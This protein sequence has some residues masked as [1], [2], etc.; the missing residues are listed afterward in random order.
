MRDVYVIGVGM[1]RFGKYLERTMKDMAAECVK[2]VLK[3]A[4]IGKDELQFAYVSNGYWGLFEGQ[5][6]IKGQVLLFPLGIQKIPITNVE[7]A[8][9]GASTAFHLAWMSI[10]SGLYDVGLALGVEKLTHPDKEL[11][12]KSFMSSMD[13]LD[14]ANQVQRMLSAVQGLP[15]KPP[16]EQEEAGRGRSIFM[17][18]YAV[19]ARWHMAKYGSTQRQLAVIS[20]KNHFHSTL[21]PLA[22]IQKDFTVEEVLA[23]RLVSYPLTRPMCAPIGDGATAAVLCSATFLK[24]L[25]YARPVKIRASVLGSGTDRGLDGEDIGARLSRKAYEIAGI[26]PEDISVAEV[27]DATAYG[28][29]HQTEVLGFCPEGAGGLFAESGATKL[30]G[31][32]P[33]NTSGGLESRGHP[34]GASGMAQIHEIVTQLR[35]EAGKRQVEDA[36]LGLTENGGGTLGFEEASM[37]IHIFE[38]V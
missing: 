14:F 38:R 3:D 11:S 26:G 2:L 6:S 28:E 4:D 12:L 17:D 35:G 23:D 20:S 31:K 13:V 37:T 36:R 1:F 10:A 7:N 24:K 25:P 30:G 18:M 29:L 8:C 9:A 5:H 22:Q 19:G 27:H 15:V 33:I 32:L 16:P 34:I 21:N